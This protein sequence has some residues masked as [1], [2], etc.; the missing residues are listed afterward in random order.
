LGYWDIAI[1]GYCNIAILQY[2]DIGMPFSG[3]VL[4]LSLD[5][6]KVINNLIN[7]LV[8]FNCHN[9]A[10]LNTKL[11]WLYT[12]LINSALATARTINHAMPH[13]TPI[14]WGSKAT[15]IFLA[16]PQSTLVFFGN[17]LFS[18]ALATTTPDNLAIPHSTPIYWGRK[19]TPIFLATPQSTLVFFGT[20]SHF[21]LTHTFS[22]PCFN[23]VY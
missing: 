20:K 19:A 8:T 18:S 13:S 9:P 12:L 7:F 17:L 10:Q 1:L 5:D 11:G 21:Y 14:Y 16:A 15:P 3:S 23:P 4:R 2:W 22:L 6:G